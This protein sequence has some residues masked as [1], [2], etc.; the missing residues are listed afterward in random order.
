MTVYNMYINVLMQELFGQVVD[1]VLCLDPTPKKL[2]LNIDWH[3]N[4]NERVC[5]LAI[6]NP[7]IWP[8]KNVFQSKAYHPCNT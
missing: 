4:E 5:I 3:D 1:A 7:E 8:H 6:K 2:N